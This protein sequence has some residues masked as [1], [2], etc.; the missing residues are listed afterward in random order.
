[1]L[2]HPSAQFNKTN[3]SVEDKDA[4]QLGILLHASFQKQPQHRPGWRARTIHP[5]IVR[6]TPRRVAEDSVYMC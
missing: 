6:F 4:L 2:K 5:P 1:M 3:V